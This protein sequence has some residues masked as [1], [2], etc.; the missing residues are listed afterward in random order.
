MLLG[1]F[2]EDVLVIV[3]PPSR[4]MVEKDEPFAPLKILNIVL[5]F[6]TLISLSFGGL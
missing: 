2:S 3:V 4:V 6:G 1:L 5:V